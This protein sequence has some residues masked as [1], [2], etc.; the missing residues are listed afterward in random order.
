MT[1][2]S[3]S[4]IQNLIIEVLKEKGKACIKDFPCGNL[5]LL[6]GNL[7]YLVNRGI[8]KKNNIFFYL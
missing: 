8:I 4:E 1:Q 2:I 6:K 5:T 3:N 7:N